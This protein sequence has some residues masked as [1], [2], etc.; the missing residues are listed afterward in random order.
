MSIRDARMAL[1][2]D[3]VSFSLLVVS[4]KKSRSGWKNKEEKLDT[5]SP[6]YASSANES[7]HL[8]LRCCD[9]LKIKKKAQLKIG[10]KRVLHSVLI[11]IFFLEVFLRLNDEQKA[12]NVQ[13]SYKQRQKKKIQKR[14]LR[15]KETNNKS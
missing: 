7:R 1:L 4:N 11:S 8:N 3:L 15:R 6:H 13:E 9:Y 2:S 12:G 5:C 14:L 10:N